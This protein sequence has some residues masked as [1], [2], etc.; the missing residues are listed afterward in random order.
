MKRIWREVGWL[1]GGKHEE[2]AL[3]SLLDG[4]RTWVGELA[5][6]VESVVSVASGSLRYL[7]ED[8]PFAGIAGVTTSRIARRRGLATKLVAHAISQIAAE[9]AAMCGL[10]MF[11]QGYYDRFGFGTGTYEHSFT[12]DPAAL[13]V[14]SVPRIPI[15]LGPDDWERMHANRVSRRRSHGACNIDSP[16]IT[17]GELLGA[18]NGFGLGYADKTGALTHHLWAR[19]NGPESGPYAV[20]WMAYRTGEELRE[21]LALVKTWGDQVR[22]VRMVEPPG[23]Q[24]QDFISRPFRL[25]QLTRGG[26]FESQARA[27]AYWQARIIDLPKCMAHTHLGEKEI[28]FNLSLTD[29]IADYLPPDAPWRGIGGE[30]VVRLGPESS[31][32]PGME[33][34]LPTLRASVGAFTRLWLGVLPAS[35]LAIS[36]NLAGSEKL[37][38]ALDELLR[39]P[40]PHLDWDF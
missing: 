5:G 4:V 37:I 40:T 36:D 33:E 22:A 10:G 25:H 9:G 28:R 11:D 23:V 17:R 30:Y 2:E 26:K 14:D 31:A 20:E 24:L 39:L 21:L 8:I 38:A 34:G 1:T 12:F 6:S 27:A 19:A 18:K 35:G 7:D 16:L 3:K 29:P 32:I 15:R 13:T